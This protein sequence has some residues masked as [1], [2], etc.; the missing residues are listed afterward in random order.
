MSLFVLV[1]SPLCG[2]GTWQSTAQALRA[3][4]HDAIVPAFTSDEANPTP[5]WQQQAHMITQHLQELDTEQPLIWVGHS[6]AGLRLP[7]YRN[8]VANPAHGYVFV[9]AGLPYDFPSGGMSQLEAMCRERSG[10]AEGLREFLISGE[11]FPNWTDELLRDDIPSDDLRAMMLRELRPQSLR[12]FDE[13]I[14]VPAKWPDAPCAFLHFSPSYNA[15]AA[16]AIDH[17]WAYQ[18]IE[19]GHFYMLIDPVGTAQAIVNL[20]SKI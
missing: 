5:L 13:P 9:D 8:A 10:F 12:Y 17:H 19:A 4:G 2:P 7:A 11:Q 3:L 14:P 18:K 20:K 1:H 6:G 16:Y 15:D